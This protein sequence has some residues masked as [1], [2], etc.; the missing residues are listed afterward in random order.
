MKL[1]LKSIQGLL[2]AL[3]ELDGVRKNNVLEPYSFSAKTTWNKAKNIK[4]LRHEHELLNE[5]RLELVV[6][7]SGDK[8]KDVP[9]EKASEFMLEYQD[10][11]EIEQD[12]SGLLLFKRENFNIFDEKENPK[13]NKIAS[14]TLATLDV[15]IED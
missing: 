5:H 2:V 13:G 14:T 1:K 11:L 4:I 8:T 12:I 15:L 3:S 10:L 7:Y 9:A 6:K